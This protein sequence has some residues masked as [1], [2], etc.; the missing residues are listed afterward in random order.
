M[1]KKRKHQALH[2]FEEMEKELPKFEPEEVSST[3]AHISAGN[4]KRAET[5]QGGESGPVYEPEPG[6]E[7]R[8]RKRKREP[9]TGAGTHDGGC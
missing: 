2:V 5:D 6:P 3:L 9:G 4:R 8:L 7:I 1:S